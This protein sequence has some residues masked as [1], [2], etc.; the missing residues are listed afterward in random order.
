MLL[1][2]VFQALHAALLRRGRERVSNSRSSWGQVQPPGFLQSDGRRPVFCWPEPLQM[3]APLFLGMSPSLQQYC[4]RKQ[5]SKRPWK[6]R[7]F[8]MRPIFADNPLGSST[9]GARKAGID[10]SPISQW[11]S[12]RQIEPSLKRATS[13][14]APDLIADLHMWIRG[15][16]RNAPSRRA[17]EANVFPKLLRRKDIDRPHRPAAFACELMANRRKVPVQPRAPWTEGTCSARLIEGHRGTML[18]TGTG[19]PRLRIVRCKY[20]HGL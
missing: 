17:G 8:Q 7:S 13:S 2:Q 6:P 16:A 1:Y 19:R 15:K 11:F 14:C 10:G 9:F 3:P 18:A 4:M 12:F 5:K 20:S